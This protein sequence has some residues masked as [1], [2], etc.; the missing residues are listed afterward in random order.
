MK[1]KNQ[2]PGLQF[3]QLLAVDSHELIENYFDAYSPQRFRTEIQKKV[4]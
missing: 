4:N 3:S 2:L 1:D